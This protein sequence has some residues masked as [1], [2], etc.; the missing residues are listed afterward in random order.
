MTKFAKKII[1][2]ILLTAVILSIGCIN[3]YAAHDTDIR[4]VNVNLPDV[5]FEIEGSYS[6]DDIVSVKL[7]NEELKVNDSYKFS[8]SNNKLVYLLVDVSTSMSQ[9]AL[10]ALKPELKKFVSSF[11]EDDK[12]VLMTFGKKV[13]TVIK[14]TESKAK[15]NKTI[16]GLKCNSPGTTFYKAL[17]KAFDASVKQNKYDRKYAIVVSDG[18]DFEKG[19]SSQEEVINKLETNRLPF[20][21]MCLSAASAKNANGFGY[22]SRESGGELVKFSKSDAKK[23]FQELKTTINNVTIFN[24]SSK[25]KKTIGK[26][27]LSVKLKNKTIDE[28]VFVKA[29]NDRTKPEL[30]DIGFDKETNSFLFYFSENV[31][32]A[33][34][35]SSYSIK[36]GEK[37]QTIVS[38]KYDES[39]YVATVCM[40]K[41]VYSADYTFVLNNITDVSD[42]ENQLK[43]STYDENI[44]ANPVIFKILL[45]AAIILVPVL[46]LLAVYLILLNLKKKKK[47]EKI[48]D[49]FVTQ[50]EEK[51]Y[52]HVHIEQP[53]GRQIKFS[54]DAGNGQYHNINFN[55]IKSVIVGRSD[56]CDLTIE[57]DKM[58]RQHF[59]IEDVENG[60]AVTDLETTNGTFVN[61]V[62]IGSRT[63]IDSGAKIF[64]GNSVITV[65]Y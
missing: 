7:D 15:I 8:K 3:S 30:K 38:I 54:I 28:T 4:Q 34:K 49:I 33:E 63:F 5:S 60:L 56:I 11:G 55:L 16:D 43:K 53:K 37:E 36:K 39:E 22:I 42:N 6:K 26:K 12:F 58:S 13:T 1:C 59:V 48:K 29:E 17:T 47:V 57:D 40:D 65:N 25:N 32:N 51:E 23:K 21:G 45:I 61:G 50:I 19:N 18:A 10:D 64:A 41:K 46:F 24:A 44:K 31:Q 20:Y 2:M 9:S 52:E 14:G 35:N 27:I 62:K